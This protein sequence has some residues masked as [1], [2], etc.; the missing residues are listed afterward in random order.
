[1][2]LEL[3][4]CFAQ[5]VSLSAVKKRIGRLMTPRADGKF[6]VPQE[7][8]DEWHK[9]DQDKIAAEFAQAGLDKDF[10]NFFGTHPLFNPGC[11][12]YCM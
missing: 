7:L 6:K 2:G 10:S 3:D 5:G 1:M 4:G 11:K 12:I 9:G 8:V